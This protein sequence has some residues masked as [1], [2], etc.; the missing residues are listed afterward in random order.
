MKSTTGIHSFVVC[1][2]EVLA[3]W[4]TALAA[5]LLIAG[6]F[7]LNSCGTARGFGSDVQK[8]GDKIEDAASR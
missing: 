2:K 8:T 1:L 3:S 7:G 4:P 6:S 5:V